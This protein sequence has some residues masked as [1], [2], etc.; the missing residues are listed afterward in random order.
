M[1]VSDIDQATRFFREALGLAV[2]PIQRLHDSRLN[3][4]LWLDAE[5][6]MRTADIGF[7][8]EVLRLTVFDPPSAS[9]PSPRASN[10]PC[11]EHVALVAGDI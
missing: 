3:A 4:L 9:Y 5:T 2:G 6:Q 7:G 10:D 11:F 8:A 1:T